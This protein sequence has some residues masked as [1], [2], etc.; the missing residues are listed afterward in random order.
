M[1]VSIPEVSAM[2]RRMARLAAILVAVLVFGFA[3]LLAGVRTVGA[4]LLVQMAVSLY[5]GLRPERSRA[6][7]DSGCVRFSG[8]SAII[9]GLLCGISGAVMLW[10]P[11]AVLL[12]LGIPLP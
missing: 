11:R 1:S 3:G 6:A 12:A 4:L 7:A 10:N 5:Q 8:R 2:G 9:V